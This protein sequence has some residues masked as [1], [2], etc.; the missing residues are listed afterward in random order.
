MLMAIK[1][2]DVQTTQQLAVLMEKNPSANSNLITSL[3]T[4]NINIH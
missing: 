2:Q 1:P 3:H 4:I